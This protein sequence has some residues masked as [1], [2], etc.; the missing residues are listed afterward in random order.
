MPAAHQANWIAMAHV[1]ATLAL[2]YE[3]Q[4]ANMV[5]WLT[6]PYVEANESNIKASNAIRDRLVTI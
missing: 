5:A 4:T 1:Q 2:A 6:L 3:A